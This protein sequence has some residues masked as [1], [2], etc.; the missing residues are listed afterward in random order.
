MKTWIWCSA[1]NCVFW[2]KL[3]LFVGCSTMKLI[4]CHCMWMQPSDCRTMNHK[5]LT[6]FVNLSLKLQRGCLFVL[7]PPTPALFIESDYLAQLTTKTWQILRYLFR[8]IKETCILPLFHMFY[9]SVMCWSNGKRSAWT[10]GEKRLTLFSHY[11]GFCSKL[12]Q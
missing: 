11:R 3:C 8:I 5:S 9:S 12:H 6:T 7:A 1:E 4:S 10:L 2:V